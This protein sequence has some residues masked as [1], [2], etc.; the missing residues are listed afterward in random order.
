MFLMARRS[1]GHVVAV[2]RPFW[3]DFRSTE[4]SKVTSPQISGGQLGSG[5]LLPALA[6]SG[7]LA[8]I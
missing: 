5:I 4:G 2:W 7:P 8:G 1:S 3:V 6:H